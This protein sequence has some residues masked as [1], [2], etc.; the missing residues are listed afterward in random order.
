MGLHVIQLSCFGVRN[1]ALYTG[2]SEEQA[3]RN[4]AH[5]FYDVGKRISG[6]GLD[7]FALLDSR[8]L[9]YIYSSVT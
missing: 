6:S 5:L 9:K 7:L 3:Y 8:V 2:F 4:N 1:E